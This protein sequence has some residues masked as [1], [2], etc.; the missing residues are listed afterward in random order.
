MR[1]LGRTL[2]VIAILAALSGAFV[3][4]Q[5]EVGRKAP[6]AEL[7]L[8]TRESVA[9]TAG[10]GWDLEFRLSGH[11]DQV[12]IRSHGLVPRQADGPTGRTFAYA[13]RIAILASDGTVLAERNE[14]LRTTIVRFRDPSSGQ[15]ER[16]NFVDDPSFDVV[17]TT[18]TILDLADLPSAE[19][20]R[21]RLVAAD[22]DIREVGV[23]VYE[24]EAIP[25]H[26]IAAS[27]QRLSLT[28]RERLAE[29][30]VFPVALLT[31]DETAAILSRRWRP[32]GPAGI[33]GKDYRVRI[34]YI[35]EEGGGQAEKPM[36]PTGIYV[37]TRHTT[38]LTITERGKYL[39]RAKAVPGQSGGPEPEPMVRLQYGESPEIVIPWNG[40][41]V[42]KEVGLEP[43]S[44]IVKSD[45]PAAIRVYRL[46]SEDRVEVLPLRRATRAF[47]VSAS[48]GVDYLVRR[49]FDR[50]AMLRVELRRRLDDVQDTGAGVTTVKYAALDVA[51]Q[52]VST[53]LIDV[54]AVPSPDS[55]LVDDPSARL[56]APT[57]RDLQLEAGIVRLRL[58]ADRPVFVTAYNRLESNLSNGN[59]LPEQWFSLLPVDG[60]ELIR[61]G[62]TIVVTESSDRAMAAGDDEEQ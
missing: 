34:L 33:E 11:A 31:E 17:G 52:V 23:R 61:D 38:S 39:I 45:R 19:V 18:L 16:V 55:G 10:E 30:N 50:P 35:R 42:E 13:L 36:I 22:S 41:S 9:Y 25:E 29:G 51:G 57:R 47:R 62:A 27:W 5:D 54:D 58:S 49:L 43:G 20:L 44:L 6:V 21:I 1:L 2:L 15:Y 8:E 26:S 40:N 3:M 56:S 32:V 14:H 53:G 48:H 4:I 46:T 37:D 24:P 12:R 59:Q 60:K 7:P 28:Q